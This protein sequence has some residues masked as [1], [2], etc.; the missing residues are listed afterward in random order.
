MKKLCSVKGCPT[1]FDGPKSRCPA[2]ERTADR[3]R[4]TSRQRGYDREH[5]N[6][7]RRAVLQRDPICVVCGHRP[8]RDAD[9]FPRS[10]RELV[11]AG[12]DPN[13]PSYGRGL[14][15]PCHSASTARRQP[16]GWAA[17]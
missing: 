15:G 3:T 12:L 8:S 4:G 14:C 6:R 2:H 11:A 17:G 9:H 10:R 16:G 1:L 13:D 5:E 7:F